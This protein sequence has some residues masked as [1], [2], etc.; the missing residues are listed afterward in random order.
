MAYVIERDSRSGKRYV[1]VYRA[2]DGK[3]KSA[4]TY[5]SHE[6][7]AEVAEE[8][9][10]H[11]RGFLDET[12]PADKARM[13]ISEFCEERFLRYHAVSPGTRQEYGYAVK[14]HIVPYIGH[15]RISEV[16][17]ETFFNL[18]I[19]VLPAEE[20]SQVTVRATRK[21]LSAM[22]QMA[23]DEGYRNN[24]PIRSIRLPQ[25]PSKPIL[26]ASHDQWRRFEEA[27][28]YP[29]AKL[30]ARLNVTAWARRCEM[31]G[32][33]PCDFD[34]RQQM[35]NITRSTVYI[36]ARYHPSG[37]AGWF[38]K[39]NPKNG[40]WR[41]FTI[42]K[43]M[44]QAVQEH[45]EEYSLGPDDLL[46]PQWM[47]AYVRSIPVVADDDENL[48]P[49]VSK[50][51]IVHQHGTMGA[52]YAMNCRCAK[53]KAYAADYQRQWRRGQSAQRASKGELTKA[54][55]WRRDGSEFLMA[56]V[57][58]RFW[59]TARDAA[60][61]PEGFTPYNARHTGISWAIDKGVDLQKVR[62]RAGHGS[63]EVMSRYAAILDER[64]TSLADALEAIFDGSGNAVG[65]LRN[66]TG[67]D[68]AAGLLRVST[69]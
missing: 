57:W 18:L 36:T 38:T 21:V 29:P 8:E 19:K 42:S 37:T 39:P 22:C 34:F 53:C 64:E 63:L 35:L 30:Y 33:R 58:T 68:D 49:L 16:N 24:N 6:R 56:D 62:Q 15:M 67:L 44:C 32:F 46:F 12:S 2:A 55:T 5:D 23:F 45:I 10:R 61:L 47:F 48:P 20:A 14:N 1:G 13:T 28:S 4:G 26:V 31:I 17:R 9:E 50:T 51:G 65:H 40:D 7:A 41:R 54:D 27:L 66:T 11:A 69:D 59:N 25:A 52:R 60:G 3:Y 43:Q